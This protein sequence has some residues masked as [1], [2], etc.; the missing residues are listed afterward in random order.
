M[1]KVIL[2]ITQ[3]PIQIY[4]SDTWFSLD[5]NSMKNKKVTNVTKAVRQML[6]SKIQHL[7]LRCRGIEV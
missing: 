4:S 1:F 6:Q 7:P 5:R 3:V 2:I